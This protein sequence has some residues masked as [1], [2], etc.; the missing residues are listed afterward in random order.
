M[1]YKVQLLVMLLLNVGVSFAQEM[2][3]LFP[4]TP[5][6]VDNPDHVDPPQTG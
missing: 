3:P 5:G 6:M 1:T 2:K 4:D